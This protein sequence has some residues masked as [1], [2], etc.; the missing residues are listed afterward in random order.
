MLLLYPRIINEF[1]D[2]SIH[3]I[4]R[5]KALKGHA[6][7]MRKSWQHIDNA[8]SLQSYMEKAGHIEV[9]ESD[10]LQCSTAGFRC[11]FD[12]HNEHSSPVTTGQ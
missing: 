5:S 4:I 6:S 1:V 7:G 12:V 10:N 2:D 8:N 9:G 3:V 11:N